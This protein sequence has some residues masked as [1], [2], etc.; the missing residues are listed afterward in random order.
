MSASASATISTATVAAWDTIYK[1]NQPTEFNVIITFWKN[2]FT[3]LVGAQYTVN[4]MPTQGGTNRTEL[5]FKTVAT[6]HLC[7]RG[8]VVR[9]NDTEALEVAGQSAL[10]NAMPTGQ[11]VFL[12]ADGMIKFYTLRADGHVLNA[13][14]SPIHPINGYTVIRDKVQDILRC[15]SIA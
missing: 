12:I 13:R 9:Q 4:V 6:G 10:S 14:P 7:L 11:A 1:G 2:Y 5:L 8:L 3:Q 15:K